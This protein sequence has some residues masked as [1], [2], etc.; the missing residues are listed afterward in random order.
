M[1]NVIH[2]LMYVR[3]AHPVEPTLTDFTCAFGYAVIIP[4]VTELWPINTTN[5][6]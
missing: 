2:M 4:A 6:Y 1:F 5:T 3:L